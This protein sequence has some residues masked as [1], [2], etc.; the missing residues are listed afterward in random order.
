MGPTDTSAVS[1]G[2]LGTPAQAVNGANLLDPIFSNEA[3][4]STFTL[5]A[6]NF[7]TTGNYTLEFVVVRKSS[8]VDSGLLVDNLV[9]TNSCP[10]GRGQRHGCQ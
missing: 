9:L 8:S 4:Y 7:P 6:S 1:K 5:G 10:A 3:G 2:S